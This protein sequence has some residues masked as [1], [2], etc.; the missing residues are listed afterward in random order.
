MSRVSWR[1]SLAI[2]KFE[3]TCCQSFITGNRQPVGI[4]PQIRVWDG[5]KKK[6]ASK[7][8]FQRL[9]RRPHGGRG[10][11]LNTAYSDVYRCCR[12]GDFE[13]SSSPRSSG[14]EPIQ[15]VNSPAS[16]QGTG[17]IGSARLRKLV[18]HLPTV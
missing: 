9:S 5:G 17:H 2:P 15:L 16:L 13:R 1:V 18:Q 3:A 14:T 4:G 8:H 6:G 10:C 11:N 7:F 12:D